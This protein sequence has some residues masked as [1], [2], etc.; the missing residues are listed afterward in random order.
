MWGLL[1]RYCAGA[2]TFNVDWSANL[3]FAGGPAEPAIC[4][5]AAGPVG[6]EIGLSLSSAVKTPEAAI[7]RT[8]TYVPRV[9]S[10]CGN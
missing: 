7:E 5:F 1:E 6:R 8:M 3:Y 2:T 10:R 9:P 4:S